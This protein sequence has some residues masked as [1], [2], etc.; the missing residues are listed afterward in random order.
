MATWALIY[1]NKVWAFC[2]KI[3]SYMISKPWNI[4][5]FGLEIFWKQI[6]VKTYF[7]KGL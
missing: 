6:F 3:E 1:Q 4:N 2:L 7:G 5:R